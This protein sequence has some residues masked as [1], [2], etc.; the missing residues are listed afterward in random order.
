VPPETLRAS[1][2]WS[3]A[4]LTGPERVLFRRL[5]VFLG[6][7]DFDGAQAVTAGGA[8]QRFEVVDLLTLLVDKSLW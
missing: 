1:V 3:H 5:A 4:L 8:V 7:V 6:G 2:D